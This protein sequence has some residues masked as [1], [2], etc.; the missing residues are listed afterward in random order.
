MRFKPGL[1]DPRSR[2]SGPLAGALTTAVTSAAALAVLTGLAVRPGLAVPDAVPAAATADSYDGYDAKAAQQLR[3]D[4][5]LAVDSLRRAGPNVFTVAQSAL[6]LPPDQMHKQ[7]E[8]DIFS[9]KV[10]PLRAA[11]N[12]DQL[13]QDQWSDKLQK[14]KYAWNSAASLDSYPNQPQD[15]GKVFEQS[16]AWGSQLYWEPM[17]VFNPWYDSSPTAD[18][19]T[20][21]A[22]LAVGN[23]LYTNA[24]TPKEQ[25]AWTLWKKNSGK[26]EEN[27]YFVPRVFADDARIFLASGGFPRTAPEPDT[28]EFRIAVEDLKARFSVCGWHDPIDPNRVLGKQVAQAAAEWQQEV[29][30]QAAQR[31]QVLTAGKDAAKA[32]QDGTYALGMLLG[33]SW[34]ADYYTRWQDHWT[35]GG[36][37]WIGNGYTVVEVP[38]AKGMCLDVQGG[39]KT[40]GTPVQIYTCNGGAAQEWT[41]EGGEEDLHLRNSGSFKCLDVAGNASANGTKIQITDCYSTK[42][43]SWKADVRAPSVLKSL[44]T[45]KCLDLSSFTKSTDLRLWDCK[46]T[47]AQKYLIKPTGKKGPGSTPYPVK[48]QFDAAKKGLTDAQTAA[49]THLAAVKAQL[50]KAK[51]SAASSD[52]AVQASY[53][54][55]DA[56]GVPRGR[57]LM[58]GQQKA[59]ITKGAVAALTAMV[60]AG[61]TAEAA[62]RAAAADSATITQRA[63]AQTAQANA[64]FRKEAARTAELQAKAAADGAK[65]HRDNAKNDKETAEAKLAVALKAE[66]DAKA[67]AADAHA[68]RLAAEA[69]EAKAKAE[70]DTAAAKQ[71]EAA[72]HRRTADA[73]AVKAEDARKAAESSEAT[74]VARKNDAV[75]ARDKARDLNADAWDAA[76]KADA[77]RA[78]ADA[79]EAYAQAHESDEQAQAS[80]AAADAAAAHADDAE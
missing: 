48:T 62:T 15:V 31:Q 36:V 47:S 29:A 51:K 16:G 12:A 20:K 28:P 11:A 41:L 24:G 77:A 35:P 4:Q 66:G 71:S 44:T 46:D 69:E 59:Q 18:D 32:L 13:L 23:P 65:L 78:K 21:A 17:E 34:L 3:E 25:E 45:G 9:D 2:S 1:F 79:K 64:E 10:T 38:G 33:Q 54:I 72:Q 56:A 58:V 75:K 14:Q 27:V 80:R 19:K 37:G 6:A 7:L 43:Q 42:G 49:K 73:E 68:K 8:R 22:A 76:Q 30:G 70:K 50:E 61:E 63:I 26:V 57:G 55:A 67:A 53:G 40:N 52:V 60:K 74:A 5:C 39:G